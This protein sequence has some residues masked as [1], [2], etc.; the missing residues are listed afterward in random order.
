MRSV[1]TPVSPPQRLAMISV[2][3][4]PLATLGGRETGGMNVYVRELSRHLSDLGIAVDVY[5]RRQ[6]P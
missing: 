3:S 1:A 5:T 2:H 6:D 4:C